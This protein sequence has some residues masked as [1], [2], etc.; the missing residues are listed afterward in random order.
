[1]LYETIH[2]L[3]SDL[4]NAFSEMT[5][6]SGIV[7]INHISQLDAE[8]N[9]DKVVVSLLH[10]MQESTL[11]NIP[12]VVPVGTRM[13]QM[14]KK[15][16]LNLFVM[17]CSNFTGYDNALKN[18][19]FI[20]EF[21]Q[22]KRVFTDKNTHFNRD[23]EELRNL[24]DFKFTVEL[25]SPSFDELNQI[26]GTIGGKQILSAIYKVSVLQ[27][28]MRKPQSQSGIVRDIILKTK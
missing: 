6:Q 8:G 16:P 4:S 14:N 1:M 17:F 13:Q 23:S 28:E 21:F 22:S 25:Y 9:A 15:V 26:W 19:S 27:L 2:I 18:L 20:I 5:E 11:K 3:S 10:M 24:G 7:D 12:N